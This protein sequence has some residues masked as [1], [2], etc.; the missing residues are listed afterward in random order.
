M[1]RAGLFQVLKPSS[2]RPSK[3]ILFLHKSI[4]EFLAAWY[5]MNEA[6]L[7]ENQVAAGFRLIDSFGKVLKLKEIL[8]FMCEWSTEGAR[9]VFQLLKTVGSKEGLTQCRLTKTPSLD[10][11]TFYQRIFRDVS[12]ECLIDCPLSARREVHPIFLS[13]V[14][15]TISVNVRNMRKVAA[16]HLLRTSPLPN[17]L[18][19]EFVE[20]LRAVVVTCSA[21]RLE[22]SVFLRMYKAV[23]ELKS[24]HFFLKKEGEKVYLYFN[25]VCRTYSFGYLEMI[26]HLTSSLSEATQEASSAL[27][28]HEDSLQNNRCQYGNCF[29]LVREVEVFVLWTREQVRFISDLLSAVA[30]PQDVAIRHVQVDNDTVCHIN[31][32]DNLSSLRLEKVKMNAKDFAFMASSLYRA[33]NLYLLKLQDCVLQADSVSSLGENLCY[34]PQLSHLTLSGVGM[35]DQGCFSFV[36]SLKHIAYLTVFDL[37]KNHLGRGITEL[38][39][40]LKHVPRLLHLNLERTNMGEKEATALAQAIKSDASKLCTLR[41]GGNPLGRGVSVI[42]Q[43][44]CGLSDLKHLVLQDVEMTKEEVDAVSAAL[45]GIVM[46]SY[47]VCHIVFLF[48]HHH[49]L[50]HH[51]HHH[52]HHYHHHPHHPPHHHPH[53]PP[54]HHH[55]FVFIYTSLLDCTSSSLAGLGQISLLLLSRVLY[56]IPYPSFLL[57]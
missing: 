12:L 45:H 20:D 50:H 7:E 24:E 18:F 55:H 29:S 42:V 57:F 31:F 23:P 36:I 27:C 40:Q 15:G 4:Q 51:H 22:A 47:H 41:L 17:Y 8:K 28:S 49:R 13:D 14:C 52:H 32:S 56:P 53:H 26:E 1:V 35:D 19:F 34:V 44:L 10:N 2:A 25:H 48:H 39:K 30:S 5:L 54:H 37:S 43:N 11:L 3:S 38:A 9:A 21:L 16:E 33:P 46:T 6:K